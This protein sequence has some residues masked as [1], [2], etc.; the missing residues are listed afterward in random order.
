MIYKVASN[1]VMLFYLTFC[2]CCELTACIK[3]ISYTFLYKVAC[4][5]GGAWLTAGLIAIPNHKALRTF[6]HC[7]TLHCPS[8]QSHDCIWGIWQP[9]CIQA[10]MPSALESCDCYLQSSLSVSSEHQWGSWKERLQGKGMPDLRSVLPACQGNC[11]PLCALE[12]WTSNWWK[13]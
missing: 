5:R 7:K 8:S 10:L 13:R 2:L 4:S 3:F 1:S 9:V 12:K 11:P 6:N